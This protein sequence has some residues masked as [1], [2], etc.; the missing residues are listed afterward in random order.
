MPGMNTSGPSTILN[1]E[2]PKL[3][4][5][6]ELE[7]LPVIP[8]IAKP[9]AWRQLDWLARM[10]ARPKNGDPVWRENGIYADEELAAI[11]EEVAKVITGD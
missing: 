6:R 8:I 2:V 11:A 1:E 3:L 9:C 5:R 4:R 7:G 10:N